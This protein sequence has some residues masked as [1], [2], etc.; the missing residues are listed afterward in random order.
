[1]N[2]LLR[3]DLIRIKHLRDGGK[4]VTVSDASQR[5]MKRRFSIFR[6]TVAKTLRNVE[7]EQFKKFNNMFRRISALILLF[8][9]LFMLSVAVSQSIQVVGNKA[10]KGKCNNAYS[11]KEMNVNL[12]HHCVADAAFC[13]NLFKPSCDCLHVKLLNYNHTMLPSNSKYMKSL[14]IL[15]I[16]NGMLQ[17]LPE[18]FGFDHRLLVKLHIENNLIERL[19]ESIWFITRRT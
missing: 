8:V 14:R 15:Q 6:T 1:M 16:T 2:N 19:P 5:S 10:Y 17:K 9:S 11:S 12:Y 13:Q 4:N 18:N 3:V 7:T